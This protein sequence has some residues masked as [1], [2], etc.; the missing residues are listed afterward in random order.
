[1]EE[2]AKNTQTNKLAAMLVEHQRAFEEMSSEDIQWAIRNPSDAIALFNKAVAMRQPDYHRIVDDVLASL[3]SFIQVPPQE[4]GSR[5][6]ADIKLLVASEGPRV[7]KITTKSVHFLTN[8]NAKEERCFRGSSLWV[9]DVIQEAPDN[10][11]LKLLGGQMEAE[12]TLFELHYLLSLQ[13][14]GEEGELQ[15]NGSGNY[16]F[17]RDKLGTLGTVVVSWE[18]E[19]WNIRSFFASDNAKISRGS[20]V[21]CRR[22]GGKRILG[23][24][25]SLFRVNIFSKRFE[26]SGKFVVRPDN[27]GSPRFAR[28]GTRFISW[29]GDKIETGLPESVDIAYQ[30]LLESSVTVQIVAEMAGIQAAECKL[31]HVYGAVFSSIPKNLSSISREWLFFVKDKEDVLRAVCVSVNGMNLE[32]DAGYVDSSTGIKYGT[33]VFSYVR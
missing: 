4:H 1:M 9:R 10:H 32:I 16:C 15:I 25:S 20:R 12:I 29:F 21:I 11:I 28:V 27:D 18:K 5:F 6:I 13:P 24:R 3:G 22:P 2:I 8:F 33:M 17:V 26:A 31:A 14:K 19:G 23:E 30:N 7:I